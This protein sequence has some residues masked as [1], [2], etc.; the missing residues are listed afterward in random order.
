[1]DKRL[2]FVMNMAQRGMFNYADQLC[3]KELGASI[4]QMA[5]VMYV[6]N[7]PGCMQKEVVDGLG[8]KKAA[9][10]GLINRMEANGL[11][12]RVPSTEDERVMQLYATK[13]GK[14]KSEQALPMINQMNE[15]LTEDFSAE[16][17][18]SVVRFLNKVRSKIK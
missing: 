11:L 17:S 5:A 16:D 6:A 15:M 14:K 3:E 8:F 9:V 12:E 13:E 7:N 2:F 10:T 18:E 4:T 1:M